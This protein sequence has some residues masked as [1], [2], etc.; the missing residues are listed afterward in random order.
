MRR[1]QRD[2]EHLYNCY[3]NAWQSE[4]IRR[5]RRISE[6]GWVKNLWIRDYDNIAR[7]VPTDRGRDIVAVYR[8]YD[9]DD[10]FSVVEF[11]DQLDS[12]S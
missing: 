11:F 10:G 9:L 1:T 6:H 2:I 12:D 3:C 4:N 8:H 7:M 5:T